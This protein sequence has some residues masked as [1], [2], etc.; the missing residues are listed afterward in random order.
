MT[1][2]VKKV[3]KKRLNKSKKKRTRALGGNPQKRGD[4]EKIFKAS[5][6][7]PN[8]A[9][10]S[11][12][13]VVLSNGKRIDVYIPGISHNLQKHSTVMVRGGG[14]QDLPGVNYRAIRG[15]YDL[16]RMYG[17]TRSRSKYGGQKVWT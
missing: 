7:K 14:A 8:S 9:N 12:A 3:F 17:R 2:C 16:D 6:K 15:K 4:C 10:R 1:L 5:P 11:V 13:K